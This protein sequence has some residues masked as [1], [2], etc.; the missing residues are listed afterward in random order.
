MIRVGLVGLD[1]THAIAFTELLNTSPA[2]LAPDSSLARCRVVAATPGLPTD[3]PL[4]VQRRARIQHEVTTRLGITLVDSI[5]Q[6]LAQV[7][8]VMILSAD[9]RSHLPEARR[10]LP[11]GKPTYIDKPLAANAADAAE[12]FRLAEAHRTPCFSASALRFSCELRPLR[13]LAAEARAEVVAH[14]PFNSEA[15]HPTLS[16]YGIHTIEALYTVLGPGCIEVSYHSTAEAEIVVG[17]WSAGRTG[18][19]ECLRE[20]K[21]EFRVSVAHGAQRQSG[22]GF[23]YAPLIAAIAEFFATG[24]PP[25]ASAETLE[26][27]RFIDAAELSR[28]RGGEVVSLA[29]VASSPPEPRRLIKS[30]GRTRQG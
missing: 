2:A 23:T 27:L 6:L 20:G 14:G 17:R 12:I 7:D 25:V 11:A 29:S 5:A 26:I 22:Q 19:V 30:R 16:W 4:S 18:R 8:A 28:A 10:V 1:S 24:K 9:G 13:A 21:P 15:H 3:F